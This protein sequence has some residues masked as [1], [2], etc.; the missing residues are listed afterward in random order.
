MSF[1]I[2]AQAL[3]SVASS[4]WEVVT[5]HLYKQGD[6]EILRG[7]L[8]H[9]LCDRVTREGDLVSRLEECLLLEFYKRPATRVGFLDALR[10]VRGETSIWSL[11][12]RNLVERVLAQN[13]SFP[14]GPFPFPVSFDTI[15]D[16]ARS[17]T[18]PVPAPQRD[19][20]RFRQAAGP[21]SIHVRT[22]TQENAGGA[23]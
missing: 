9:L 6:W 17:S 8:I 2:T 13:S 16:A 22:Q 5:E 15:R 21:N 11:E 14:V 3:P 12:V 1:T 23:Q 10:L 20:A 18:N 19:L 7:G 4:D